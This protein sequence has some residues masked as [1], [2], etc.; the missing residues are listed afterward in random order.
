MVTWLTPD[1]GLIT[2]PI[3]GACRA[4]SLHLGHF[5]IFYT[6]ELVWYATDNNGVHQ[7]RECTAL[8]RRDPLRTA[9]RESIAGS[10]LLDLVLRTA[11]PHQPSQPLYHRLD[12]ALNALAYNASTH[13]VDPLTIILWFEIHALQSLGILPNFKAC[14]SCG[15]LARSL[16]SIDQGRLI[17]VH[18]PARSSSTA[19]CLLHYHTIDLFH[20][21][22]RLPLPEAIDWIT[23][24]QSEGDILPGLFGLRR[25]LG[26]FLNY[27]LDLLPGARA[28]AMDLLI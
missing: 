8:N 18:R 25:F 2:T 26:I 20:K 7:I 4:K 11:Q 6:S 15:P 5:D 27:H 1:Y 9:W 22:L 10:Y 12:Q 17:C 16:F 23:A 24:Q 19:S 21:L 3:K 14:S 13:A 28:T